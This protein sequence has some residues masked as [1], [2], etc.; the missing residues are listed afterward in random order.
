MK[1]FFKQYSYNI[2]KTLVNQFAISVFG[3]MLAMAA[4]A[5]KNTALTIFG[6]IF[7]IVFYLFLIYTTTW[8]VGA[9]DRISV[10]VGKKPYRPHTGL[11]LSLLANIPN[12]IIALGY[13]VFYP[14]SNQEWAANTCAVF[15]ILSII[16]EGMYRGILSVIKVAP[17]GQ[18][19]FTFWWSYFLIII[20]ALVTSWIAYY[21]GFRNVRL[22]APLFDKKNKK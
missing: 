15:S 19:M 4:T 1:S 13:T 7:S 5:A 11:M 21:T 6:S 17:L 22:V 14:F 16:F 3:I 20:P 12:F 2:V 10:D 18:Q 9:K 8:E